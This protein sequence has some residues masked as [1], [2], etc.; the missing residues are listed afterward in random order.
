MKCLC[1][2]GT[3]MKKYWVRKD[4]WWRERKYI[5]KHSRFGKAMSEETKLKIS[6]AQI[7]EKN[8][9]WKGSKVGYGALHAWVKRVLGKPSKC[10]HCL[11]SDKKKY[12]WANTNG[13]YR[14]NTKDWLRLCVS[15]HKKY[16]MKVLG[17]RHDRLYL[18]NKPII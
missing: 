9:A 4:G 1:G 8:H 17:V 7:G 18:R 5:V 2:C 16:D 13:K 11:S 3:D 6:N 15:C 12:E 10:S 14:R